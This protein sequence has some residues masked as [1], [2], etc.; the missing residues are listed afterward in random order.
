MSQ[1]LCRG[2]LGKFGANFSLFIYSSSPPEIFVMFDDTISHALSILF[3]SSFLI[4]LL[5]LLIWSI[6]VCLSR[7]PLFWGSLI[8]KTASIHLFF[9]TK[10]FSSITGFT[11][12]SEGP[13]TRRKNVRK[14]LIS[15][16]RTVGKYN[17]LGNCTLRELAKHTKAISTYDFLCFGSAPQCLKTEGKRTSF[18]KKK[19]SPS[20]L[21]CTGIINTLKHWNSYSP[22][23]KH[24]A[25]VDT[26]SKIPRGFSVHARRVKEKG[27][28]EEKKNRIKCRVK[29]RKWSNEE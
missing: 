17:S 6:I 14:E 12:S 26:K 28:A 24:C 2:K 8:L 29:A 13:F 7:I 11:E 22:L 5:S 18:L 20:I 23:L 25:V 19:Y 4:S 16:G 10:G 9:P 1:N 21:S 27:E 3:S 15:I